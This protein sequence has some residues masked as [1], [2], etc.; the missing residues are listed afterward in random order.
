MSRVIKYRQHKHSIIDNIN[1]L[2]PVYKVPQVRHWTV[3]A[4]VFSIVLTAFDT[5]I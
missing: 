2:N 1:I 3:E 5:M 4:G